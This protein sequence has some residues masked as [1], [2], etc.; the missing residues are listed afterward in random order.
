MADSAE[1]RPYKSSIM[2]EPRDCR[3]VRTR[4][5]GTGQDEHHLRQT[6]N[7]PVV[8]VAPPSPIYHYQHHRRPAGAARQSVGPRWLG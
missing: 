1:P 3:C 7:S 8:Q 6:G 4:Q 5:H 2:M